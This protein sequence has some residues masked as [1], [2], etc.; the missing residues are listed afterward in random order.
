MSATLGQPIIIENL[1]GAGGTAG[2]ARAAKSQPDGHTLLIHHLALATGAALYP[3]L[4][5]DTLTAFELIGLVNY[6]PFVLT[7][8]KGLSVST[9]KEAIEYIR[10]NKDK[11]SLGHAGVGSGSHL[12][13]LLLQSALGIKLGNL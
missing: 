5:Y 9:A 8:K 4:Q 6:N 2:A 3:N 1:A 7:S 10:A 12:C 13:N 11:I